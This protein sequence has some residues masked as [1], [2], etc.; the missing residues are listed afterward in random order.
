MKPSVPFRKLGECGSRY[1]HNVIINPINLY[2]QFCIE[3]GHCF[4]E[5]VFRTITL[6][7]KH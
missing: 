7:L 4:H 3:F 5:F 6:E 1:E 2:I